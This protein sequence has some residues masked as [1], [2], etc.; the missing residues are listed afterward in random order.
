M[1]K[2]SSLIFASLLCALS[3]AMAQEVTLQIRIKD[4]RFEPKEL[5][6]PADRPL[7]LRVINADQGPEEFE[8][9][10]LRVERVIGA[11]AESLFKLRP[12]KPGRYQFFGEY[13]DDTA[14]GS[15]LIE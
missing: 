14:Q 11:N 12:L 7:T 6:A 2:S 9:K 4:H 3:P 8:S 1:Q 13:H 5:K 10:D 15:L